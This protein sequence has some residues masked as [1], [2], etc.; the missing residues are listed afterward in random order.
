MLKE[1]REIEDMETKARAWSDR[2][3][4]VGAMTYEDGVAAALQWVLGDSD[5]EVPIEIEAPPFDEA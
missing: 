2:G 4:A 3:S 5:D 1:I